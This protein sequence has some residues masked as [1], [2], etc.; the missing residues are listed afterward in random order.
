MINARAADDADTLAGAAWIAQP[1]PYQRSDGA[2]LPY[3]DPY[4]ARRNDATLGDRAGTWEILLQDVVGR[5]VQVQLTLLGTGRVTPEIQ[6]LRLW[7]PRFSYRDHY[8]PAIY[9]E[10]AVS[11]SL[12]ER[13]LANFEGS[14]TELEDKI[15]QISTLLDPRARRRT[16]WT[17]WPAGWA[18]SCTRSGMRSGGAFSSASPTASTAGAAPWPASSPRCASSWTMR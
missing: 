16:R 7:Y 13:L 6:A 8:L 15:V 14:Y 3:Y 10:D 11:A 1:K 5:Y 18:W 17:G 2:E 9:G 4:A 12:T